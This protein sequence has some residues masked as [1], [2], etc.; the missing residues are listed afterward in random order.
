MFTEIPEE[1]ITRIILREAMDDWLNIAE[2][3]V[4]IVGAGPSGLTAAY[5]LAKKKIRT[6]VLERRVTPG[7]GIGGGGN[8][9]HKVVAAAPAD[10]VLKEIGAK[11]K[12]IRKGVFVMD[13]AELI[14][15]LL[16]AAI[17]A[18]AKVL[19]GINVED[20]IYRDNPLRITGVVISWSAIPLAQLHVDPICLKTK[21]IIDATG[22]DADVVNI[23]ARKV[24]EAKIKVKG[25]GAMYAPEGE[26]FTVEKTGEVIPGLFVTGMA[27][28]ATF[29][30]PRMGPI[31]S[32]MLLSGKKVAE[33]IA[34]KIGGCLM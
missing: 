31:F 20:V 25:E 8:L 4:V 24:P 11:Y 17:D 9:F 32:S 26:K 16:N 27:V 28:N 33:I 1:E 3:D 23:V 2:S 12:E 6:V 34:K 30:G 5:Y 29:G 15:R 13:A 7:G 22:H 21:A 10:E 18:G 14:A 19:L